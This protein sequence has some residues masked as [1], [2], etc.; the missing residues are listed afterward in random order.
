MVNRGI[1]ISGVVRIGAVVVLVTIA[2]GLFWYFRLSRSE[3]P[4]SKVPDVS[5]ADFEKIVGQGKPGIL[6]FYSTSC[7]YCRM[8]VPVLER[9]QAE[10]GDRIFVVT[11]NAERYPSEAAKYEVPGVPTLIFFDA[12]GKMTG[13]VIGYH[14]YD[15]MV[16]VL[17]QLKFI[18]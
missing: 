12:Q 1:R 2:A 16:G 9:L 14:D 7:S 4:G 10:Y 11:M 8:M 5:P 17:R 13:G 15:A 18:D 6:E 3:Q